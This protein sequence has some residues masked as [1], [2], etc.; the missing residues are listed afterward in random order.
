M[1][2]STSGASIRR[3]NRAGIAKVFGVPVAEIDKWVDSGCPYI[4]RAKTKGDAWVFD[5]ADVAN[6]RLEMIR[7]RRPLPPLARSL[8]R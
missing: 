5:T 2:E 8:R 1:S 3:V 7:S 4:K 6:W